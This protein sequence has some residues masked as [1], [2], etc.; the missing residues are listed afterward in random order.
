MEMKYFIC[1]L[2]F[3]EYLSD[4]KPEEDPLWEEQ[5]ILVMASSKEDAR[6]HCMGIGKSKEHSFTAVAGNTCHWK[7]E[8]IR[9]IY[10]LPDGKIKHGSELLSR[11]LK[12]SVVKMMEVQFDEFE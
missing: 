8:K 7:F 9:E 4:R 6:G 5:M 11:E 2:L 10:E 12:N 3:K 1:S